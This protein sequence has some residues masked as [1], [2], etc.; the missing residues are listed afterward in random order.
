MTL[1]SDVLEDPN[2]IPLLDYGFVGIKSVM[3]DDAAIVE[4][5]RVS[6]GKGTKSIRE[7]ENLIRYLM[8]LDHTSPF[9]LNAI[10]LHIKAPIFVFRQLF[11]HRTH[12]ANEMSARYT[13]MVDEFYI[14]ENDVIQSQ[15]KDNK[16]GRS[17]EVSSTSKNGVQWLFK[18]LYEVAYDGYQ[19]LLGTKEPDKFHQGEPSYDAYGASEP[20]F[21]EEF[22]GIAR[23][24]ARSVLPVGVYSELY[25]QQNLLNMF[26]LLKLR[27]DL[28]AQYEIRVYADA[29]CKLIEPYFP[30]AFK[31]FDDYQRF[32]MKLSRME[33]AITKEIFLSDKSPSE[34]IKEMING[35]A[36]TFCESRQI[37]IREFKEFLI[38]FGLDS[39]LS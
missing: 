20:L 34:S 32:S 37:S 31:A 18:A 2:Y 19:T 6:Y 1:Q 11:R 4:A 9:E 3:G 27:T 5:A 35:D 23:E 39:V 7:D 15:S 33:I 17:G 14:P 25:W 38:R 16:Q 13:E 28:H 26:K 8:R 12:S 30:M 22:N 24:L 36:K 21:D 10:K 29:I